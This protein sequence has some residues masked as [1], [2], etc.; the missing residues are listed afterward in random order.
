MGNQRRQPREFHD[1]VREVWEDQT[2]GL[3]MNF[4]RQQGGPDYEFVRNG[5]RPDRVI[6]ERPAGPEVG[7]EITRA[8]EEDDARLGKAAFILGHSMNEVLAPYFKGGR[9]WLYAGDFPDLSPAAIENLCTSLSEALRR[10]G[11][12]A[13][14][15]AGLRGG[16]WRY[17]TIE[18]AGGPLA[19]ARPTSYWRF[20]PNADAEHWS[21]TSNGIAQPQRAALPPERLLELLLER[22]RDKCKKRPGYEWSGP[23]ILLVRNPYSSYMPGASARVA[24]AAALAGEPF[25]EVWL[26]NYGQGTLEVAPPQETI[27][28]L[29]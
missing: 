21:F 14:F 6:R 18:I 22:L 7:V 27:I 23:L 28:R 1:G 26:V 16:S 17:R 29:A 15:N 3:F 19:S 12:L 11:S 20:D 24:I 9:A 8:V 2:L 13:A 25:A 4:R 10:A 5:E